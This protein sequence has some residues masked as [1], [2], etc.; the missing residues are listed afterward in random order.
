MLCLH[1]VIFIG[2]P[3]R[4]TECRCYLS[5][6]L[7]HDHA[8]GHVH[9]RVCDHG[10]VIYG[11]VLLYF[12]YDHEASSHLLNILIPCGVNGSLLN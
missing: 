5:L 11:S 1:F 8:S 9:D 3:Y 2:I 7:F 4:F 12:I 10:H 6:V